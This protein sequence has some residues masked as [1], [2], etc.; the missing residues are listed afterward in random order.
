MLQVVTEV[1]SRLLELA[2][3]VSDRIPQDPKP[4]SIKKVAQEVAV[5]EIFRNAVFGSNTTIVVGSGSIQG[6]TNNIVVNDLASLVSALRAQGVRDSD[7]EGLQQ[8]IGTDRESPE[9]QERK[10]GP[11]VRHWIASMVSKAASGAWD[12]G[13]ATA[14]G[15]LAAA[16]GAYYGISVA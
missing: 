11:A 15:E 10:L 12:I 16:I 13:I 14:G 4:E 2:L 5:S 3:Q 7:L 8:A 1:R 9:I 6:V